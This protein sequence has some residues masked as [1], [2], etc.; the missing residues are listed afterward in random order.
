MVACQTWGLRTRYV[1]KLGDDDA[2]RLHR[3]AFERAGVEARLVT[4][5]GGTSPQ[6]VILVDEG[7]ERTVLCRREERM[8]LQAAELNRDWIVN[9]RALHVDGF[10]T[11]AATKAAGWARE[12]GIPVIAD[13][14][15]VYAGVELLL[16]NIDYLIV[17]RDFPGRLMDES[18]LEQ[19]LKRM[20]NA[21]R[22]P[23]DGGYAGAG[24][25]AGVGWAC[26]SPL[27][28]LSGEGFGYDGSG[29]Y[30]PCGVHLRVAAGVA[31]GRTARLCLRGSS[32][33]LHGQWGSGRNWAG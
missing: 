31:A 22:L 14:D 24:W 10:E 4:V 11:A 21:L 26:V 7:G 32:N 18:N 25:G 13:L 2:A 29:G 16:K 9:A 12:A 20:Q 27:P 17:S 15:E 8:L 1:G 6:S 19:A 23:A 5:A 30:F 28:C 33:E 3:E